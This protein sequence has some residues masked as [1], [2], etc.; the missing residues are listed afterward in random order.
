MGTFLNV[1][2]LVIGII[3]GGAINLYMFF[4]S[5][6]HPVLQDLRVRL[7]AVILVMLVMVPIA[8]VVAN[9]FLSAGGRQGSGPILA[10]NTPQPTTGAHPTQ[11]QPTPTPTPSPT[12][13]PVHN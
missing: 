13:T 5:R 1:Y 3:V 2:D 8:S 12:P 4:E 10:T 11:I 9:Q 7:I 6:K